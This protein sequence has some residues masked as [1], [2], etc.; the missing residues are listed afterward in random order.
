MSRAVLGLLLVVSWIL[1]WGG[2][3]VAN[4][5]SG[6]LVVLLLYLVFPSTRPAWPRTV[7]HPGAFVRLLGYFVVQL[8]VST[9]LIAREVLTPR[10]SLQSRVIDVDMRTSSRSLLTLITSMV[11]LTPGTMAV[12]VRSEPPL[13][14]VH[15]LVLG[16]PQQVA[17][18]LWRLEELCVR[19][20]GTDE[21]IAE[22]EG[23]G[24]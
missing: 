21:A 5:V 9:L 15:A 12:A 3:T 20:F 14:T 7:I 22:I 18:Q 1:L 4:V 6:T 10:S 19:A 17:E 2:L 13:I 23:A 24:R 8:V 16:D 11:A